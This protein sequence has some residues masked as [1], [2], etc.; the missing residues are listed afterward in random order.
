L[1]CIGARI[2]TQSMQS[3]MGMEIVGFS[4]SDKNEVYVPAAQL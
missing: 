3:F 1:L 4:D 2:P